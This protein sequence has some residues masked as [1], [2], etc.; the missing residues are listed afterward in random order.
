[1]KSPIRMRNLDAVFAFAKNV[2]AIRNEHL[3]IAQQFMQQ[4]W[5]G[6]YDDTDAIEILKHEARRMTML[7]NAIEHTVNGD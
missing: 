5:N 3:Q 2:H 1:M 7:A 4:L 6:D